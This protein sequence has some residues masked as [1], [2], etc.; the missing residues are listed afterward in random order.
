MKIYPAI[1]PTYYRRISDI[2]LNI[3][4]KYRRVFLTYRRN[5]NCVDSADAPTATHRPKNVKEVHFGSKNLRDASLSM[6]LLAVNLLRRRCYL[7][8]CRH[9]LIIFKSTKKNFNLK[10]RVIASP[11]FK[12]FRNIDWHGGCSPPFN[13]FDIPAATYRKRYVIADIPCGIP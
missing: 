8:D 3:R 1:L 10:V 11:F 13:I 9:N 7:T 5:F 4:R 12:M 6:Q 2:Q